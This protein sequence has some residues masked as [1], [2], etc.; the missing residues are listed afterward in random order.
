MQTP[1]NILVLHA[2]TKDVNLTSRS[3]FTSIASLVMANRI[4]AISKHMNS[5]IW[6][7]QL[8]A[9]V[10]AS[11]IWGKK[12]NV[13]G[14]DYEIL[15]PNALSDLSA[16][17]SFKIFRL[18]G[19]PHDFDANQ[20]QEWI[21]GHGGLAW[22]GLS[23]E[24]FRE[25]DMRHIH[26]GIIRIKVSYTDNVA[27]QA[28]MNAIQ[29]NKTV[30]YG[31]KKVSFLVSVAGEQPKCL[32]CQQLGHIRVNC[33]A[34]KLKCGTC[35]R[36]G[37]LAADCKSNTF[38]GRLAQSIADKADEEVE[39]L[40]EEGFDDASPS[41]LTTS[42]PSVVQTQTIKLPVTN[43]N[44]VSD[45]GTTTSKKS[46][47]A[48]SMAAPL[49]PV[50]DKIVI[51]GNSVADVI[52]SSSASRSRSTSTCKSANSVSVKTKKFSDAEIDKIIKERNK[53]LTR[54]QLDNLFYTD[55]PGKRS[56]SD[57]SLSPASPEF[58]THKK[59]LTNM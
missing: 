19:L 12:V 3:I 7:I 18:H 51:G 49:P 20:L 53:S 59:A 6:V 8:D 36:S 31:N 48:L 2:P 27:A 47:T 34:Y 43:V 44:S 30:K 10:S 17:K 55:A 21:R 58:N 32:F 1:N 25:P 39:D 26:N 23:R 13:S 22:S 29:G 38:A 14:R 33:P 5:R 52:R 28:S 37:H 16:R 35:G 11:N 41:G 24:H 46:A 40:E 45:N 57:A 9:T 54:Q 50:G 4:T 56:V 15:P 42:D